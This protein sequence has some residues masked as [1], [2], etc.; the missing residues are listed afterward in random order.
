LECCHSYVFYLYG[1]SLSNLIFSFA[2]VVICDVGSLD[3]WSS[4]GSGVFMN[5]SLI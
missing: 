5:I 4:V 2:P 1:T 3:C